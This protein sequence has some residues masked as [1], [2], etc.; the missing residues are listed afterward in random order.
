MDNANLHVI[1]VAADRAGLTPDVL[2]AWE[3]RYGAVQPVRAA[4]GQRVYSD[5]DVERLRLLG[6]VTRAG[7]SIGS[8]AGLSMEALERM[9]AED[10][11]SRARKAGDGAEPATD[12]IIARSM[13]HVRRL[14][15]HDLALELHRALSRLGLLAFLEQVATRLLRE[16]GNEWHAGRLSPA[17]EHHSSAV[18][19]DIIA[20]TMRV[21]TPTG[22]A[23]TIVASTLPGERHTL[24]AV[25]VGAIAASEG[26]RVLYLGGDLPATEIASAAQNANADAVAISIVY[27]DDRAAVREDLLK[28]RRTL[29]HDVDLLIGGAGAAALDAPSDIKRFD[30]LSEFRTMLSAV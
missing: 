20:G 26:W 2:R 9:A 6:M 5:A 22:S 29:N 25:M 1:T 21:S 23:P 4:N 17:Q 7:R 11:E 28:V 27:P 30:S 10:A 18:L 19:H 12:P 16:I 8:V 15:T 24:G 3:R 14:A 13:D